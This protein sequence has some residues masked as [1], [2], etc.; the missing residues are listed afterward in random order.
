MLTSATDCKIY[1]YSAGSWHLFYCPAEG[2][3]LSGPK[4]LVTYRDCIFN[5]W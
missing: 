2:R 5:L 4:W 1:Y 3:R